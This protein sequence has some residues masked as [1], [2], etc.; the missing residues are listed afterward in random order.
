MD[1]G[2]QEAADLGW[3][4]PRWSAAMRPPTSSTPTRPNGTPERVE[5]VGPSPY[6]HVVREGAD[7][8]GPEAG[9]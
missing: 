7:A 9:P 3:K 5:G 8:L 1:T 2:L 4:S 6:A